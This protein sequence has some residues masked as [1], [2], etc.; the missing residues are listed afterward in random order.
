MLTAHAKRRTQQRSIPPFAVMLLE[1][2]GAAGRYCGA[3]VLFMNKE[4][5]RRMINDFGGK[6][7]LRMVE[8][9]LDAYAVVE[10]GSVITLA[11]RTRRLKR[12]TSQRRGR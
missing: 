6:R 3:D 7:A 11:H 2:Y 4:G 1:T 5:R 9:L 10:Q 12:D 8:P